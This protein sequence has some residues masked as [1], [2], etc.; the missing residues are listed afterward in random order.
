MTLWK[1][2][3]FYLSLLIL[4][5]GITTDVLSSAAIQSLF[6]DRLP[7]YDTLFHILPYIPWTQ[8]F[9]DLANIFSVIILALYIFPRRWRE[10]PFVLLVIGVSYLARGI[11]ILLNPFGGPLGNIATY[12][13]TSIHQYGQFPSGHVMLVVLIF[14]FIDGNEQP[15]LK[16]L[17]LLSCFVEVAALLTSH[18]HYS[19]DIVGG[20]L[21][22]YFTSHAL[23]TFKP[24]ITSSRTAD[25][26]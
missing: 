3:W 14:F 4:A 22:A 10:L 15:I 23:R 13:L 26:V 6:P 25:A 2:S 16:R 24:L 17:A 21:V 11:L 8:Y 7:I 5:V 1:N 18:G 12:G 9:S 19:I 20:F